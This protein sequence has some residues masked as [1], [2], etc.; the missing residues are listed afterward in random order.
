MWKLALRLALAALVLAGVHA[1]VQETTAADKDAPVN[2]T[3]DYMIVTGEKDGQKIPDERIAGTL[4]HFEDE[5][6]FVE[7]RDHKSTPYV[8]TY[9]VDTTKKPFVITMKC[10]M[11][12]AKGETA[13][14]LIE[15]DGD[16][17]RLIYALP[18]GEQPT[19][20]KTKDKQLLFVMKPV[21]K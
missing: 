10:I 6:V 1:K 19:D 21:R 4:V 11:G 17:L 2:L 18:G 13:K 7:D 12:L 8:A 3:G 20:F 5:Q 15:K 9:T 16:Q 14:G